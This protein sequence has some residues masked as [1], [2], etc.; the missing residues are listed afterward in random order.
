MRKLISIFLLLLFLFNLV[1]Y[2][3]IFY[4][5]QQ[6]SDEQLKASFDK[7]DYDENDLIAVRVP[8]SMPYLDNSRDFE[9]VNGE[10]NFN[11][12]IYKYVKRKVEDGQLVLMCI[13][14]EKKMQ[15]ESKKNDFFKITNDLQQNSSSKKP[16]GT[17][18]TTAKN[19]MSDYDK[20][21]HSE[22]AQL[23]ILK[24]QFLSP[25]D[26]N[27]PL[28]VAIATPEQPPEKTIV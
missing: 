22:L 2:K 28:F 23:C 11:G 17:N 5:E 26:N 16:G 3:A 21:N 8:I 27:S 15:I 4:F 9:R 14:D 10:I 13:P 24:Q 20:D 25:Q 18:N 1:G 19:F 12:K 6:Q 7:N